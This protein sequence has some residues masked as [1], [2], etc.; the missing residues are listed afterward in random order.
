MKDRRGRGQGE[1]QGFRKSQTKVPRDPRSGVTPLN[2]K[3]EGRYG[4]AFLLRRRNMSGI[5]KSVLREKGGRRVSHPGYEEAEN[6]K[7]EPV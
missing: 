2:Q 3:V 1:R 7:R 4:V 5:W 6:P